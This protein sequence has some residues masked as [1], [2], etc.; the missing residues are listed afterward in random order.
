MKTGTLEILS[1]G[2]VLALAGVMLAACATSDNGASTAAGDGGTAGSAPQLASTT[3]PAPDIDDPDAM[4][5]G[6]VSDPFEDWNRFVFDL[7]TLIYTLMQPIIAPYGVLPDER[8]RNVDNF[9]HNLSTP[10]ILVNDLLQGETERAWVT[11]QRFVVNTAGGLGFFD[12]ATDMGLPKHSEDFGQTLG[13]WGVG[14]GPYMVYPIIGP[15]NPRDGIGRV[16]DMATD[17]LFWLS[18]STAEA[19]SGAKTYTTVSAQVGSNVPRMEE[20]RSN[21]LD[22]Y[23][24]VRSLYTQS[25][26]AAIANQEGGPTVGV[27]APPGTLFDPDAEDA[28]AGGA[29]SDAPAITDLPRSGPDGAPIAVAPA[30]TADVEAAQGDDTSLGPQALRIQ[31]RA[32]TNAV[33]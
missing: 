29:G 15:S 9:V 32:N 16:V 20:L 26:R 21:S 25:R 3:T 27:M 19:L 28:D 1:R 22:F 4:A 8:K 10:V 12:P 30:E 14:D 31:V 17:P 7:N 2:A 24:A 23:A 18:G 33:D 13:V 5:G 6:L 11:T